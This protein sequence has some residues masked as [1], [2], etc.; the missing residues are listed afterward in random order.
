MYFLKTKGTNLIPDFMQVRDINFTLIAHFRVDRFAEN[1]S[2]INISK[3]KEEVIKD[4]ENLE[5][6]V[7]FEIK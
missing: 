6:G 1:L 5:Y 3:N 2:K 4:I 7:L